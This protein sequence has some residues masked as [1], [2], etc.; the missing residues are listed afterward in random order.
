MGSCY[1]SD[2]IAMF[3]VSNRCRTGGSVLFLLVYST[4]ACSNG[5]VSWR[6]SAAHKQL[7]HNS[8]RLSPH[9]HCPRFCPRLSLSLPLSSPVLSRSSSPISSVHSIY[10]SQL[11]FLLKSTSAD[12]RSHYV[13]WCFFC[14]TLTDVGHAGFLQ[15]TRTA[16]VTAHYHRVKT[17]WRYVMYLY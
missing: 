9:H 1:S 8:L 16:A 12:E 2:N 13:Q 10:C 5:G 14:V 17:L 15:Q 11:T 6:S 4:P 3:I 7:Q